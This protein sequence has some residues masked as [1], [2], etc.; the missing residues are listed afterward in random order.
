MRKILHVDLD[1]FF[2]SVEE[3][4]DPDLRGVAFATG[5][6][7]D[8]RG[9]VT[10]C[11]YAARLKGI[12]SAMPMSS[13]LRLCP[14]LRT[15]RSHYGLY[16]EY[17]AKVMGIFAQITPLVEPISIDE[18]FLDVSDLP[19]PS[20]EIAV[21]IQMRVRR[22]TGLPCSIGAAANKLVAKIATNIGKSGH[23]QPTPP[24]AIKVI[25]PGEEQEFLRLLPVREMWGIGPKSAEHLHQHGIHLIGD[26]QTMA[27]DDL[28]RI[29]GNFASTLKK[30]SLGIDER[31]VGDDDG[32]K[33][34]SNEMTFFD[35]ISDRSELLAV[36]RDL[37]IKVAGRLRKRGLNGKTV[38]VKLRWADYTT[39][40]RQATIAQPTN[41]DSVIFNEAEK[42]V[43]ENWK[44]GQK[45][46]LV[47]VGVSHLVAD[48]QQLSLFDKDFEKERQLLK[49]ID[50][51]QERYGTDIIQRGR[52]K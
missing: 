46:R 37:A 45:V 34:V 43:L 17:S 12:H 29:V 9:V 26:I 13:A 22:E 3:Q 28:Q 40:T 6:T 14:G 11:S 18:A 1:A 27:D 10:S 49:A 50:A 33:S 20:K 21:E 24:M 32:V 35:S 51:L 16:S 8:G 39:I 15:V 44:P 42:L 30:R 31:P 41:H 48:I 5:G 25:P 7:A 2:C 47:G 52:R 4:L 19:Q 38:R 23:L 36:V